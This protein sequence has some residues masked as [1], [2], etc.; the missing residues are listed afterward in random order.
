M[1]TVEFYP[2]NYK[3]PTVSTRETAVKAAVE[4]AEELQNMTDLKMIQFNN[5]ELKEMQKMS[6]IFTDIAAIKVF[7]RRSDKQ[8]P[9]VE[10]IFPDNSMEKQNNYPDGELT[11][12]DRQ[13]TEEVNNIEDTEI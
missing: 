11:R 1:D 6:T 2:A 9:R 7:E 12:V 13:V 8:L 3:M 5:N 10:K 4:L